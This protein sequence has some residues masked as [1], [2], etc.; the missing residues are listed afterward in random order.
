MNIY[1]STEVRPYIYICTHKTTGKFYIGY[2]EANKI[3]SHLDFPL[4]KTSSKIVRPDF[5][6]YTWIIF[7]EFLNGE[8]AYQIEQQLIFENWSNPLLINQHQRVHA[9]T[10]LRG[11]R[12]NAVLSDATKKKIS[13]ANKGKKRST[14]FKERMAI[15]HQG[16]K[17][18]LESITKMKMRTMSDSAKAHLSSINKGKIMSA[19]TKEKLRQANLGKKRG[20]YKK[21]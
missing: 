3:A 21:D 12:K 13:D 14:E 16:K 6:N 20:K 1:Q 10:P 2:R 5:D 19:E 8:S 9:S 18:S 4:Y 11:S 7:A 17:H 15:L